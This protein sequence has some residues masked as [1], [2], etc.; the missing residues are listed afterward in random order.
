MIKS[1]HYLI[2]ISVMGCGYGARTIS[3]GLLPGLTLRLMH[4]M[5]LGAY[6]VLITPERRMIYT[7]NIEHTRLVAEE[8][9]EALGFEYAVSQWEMGGA[10]ADEG[11]LTDDDAIEAELRGLRSVLTIGEQKRIRA[12]GK[13]AS[14]ALE[15]ATSAVRPGDTEYEIGARLRATCQQ[16]GMLA[17]V[18][19]VG[20]DDRISQHRHPLM[21]GKRLERYGMLVLCARRGGLIFAAT[22][23]AHIGK[24]PDELL[25]KLRKI[26]TID[27]TVMQATQP[28]R[29]LGDVFSDLQDAYAEQGEDDQWRYHH[30]GGP[31][32]YQSRELIATP[33]DKTMIHPHMAF[34]WNP[35]I[36]GC[37]SEDTILV[38]ED[39]YEIVTSASSEFPSVTVDVNGK[40]VKRAGILEI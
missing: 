8:D 3:P 5:R 39:G 36:V 24:I 10:P 32:A 12:L 38:S 20:T 27:V 7:N 25:E 22:R 9:F 15:E 11:L 40:R 2:G 26:V 18:V 4:P 16:R 34:A 29:T 30:Q 23:L 1:V 21:T 37:K 14:L 19:L 28:G 17:V 6:S 33:D 31:I 35:S 13:D